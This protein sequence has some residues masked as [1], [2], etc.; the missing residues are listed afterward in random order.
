M[1]KTISPNSASDLI[2]K[3]IQSKQQ[4]TSQTLQKMYNKNTQGKNECR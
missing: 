3:S 2:P 4:L 1:T